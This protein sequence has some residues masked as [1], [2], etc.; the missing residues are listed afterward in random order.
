MDLLK[1]KPTGTD[2][3]ARRVEGRKGG[4]ERTGEEEE[5][6]G[7]WRRTSGADRDT[8]YQVKG[9]KEEKIWYRR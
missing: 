8:V 7:L 4:G 5:E 2:R 3:Y 1:V 6:T 9:N